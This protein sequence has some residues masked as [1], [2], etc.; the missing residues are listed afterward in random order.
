MLAVAVVLVALEP[1][2]LAG[3]RET[4]FG[5][6]QGLMPRSRASA[7]AMIVAIDEASL[8]ARGQWP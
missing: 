8:D 4:L 1:P 5:A 3:W 2:R 7:P 6:Y